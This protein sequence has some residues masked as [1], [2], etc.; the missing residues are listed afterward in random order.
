MTTPA[1]GG[2]LLNVSNTS[3]A[4]YWIAGLDAADNTAKLW[5]YNGTSL[6]TEYSTVIAAEL[7]RYDAWYTLTVTTTNLGG[8]IT[9]IALT[10]TKNADTVPLASFT[11]STSR[12]GVADG[13]LGIAT[14]RAAVVFDYWSVADA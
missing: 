14:N 7:L 13:K 3:S 11:I 8:G 10:V 5:R 2:I 1:N 9:A 6:I 12:Y 4:V